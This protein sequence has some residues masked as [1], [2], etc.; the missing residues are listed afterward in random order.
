[1]GGWR[2]KATLGT[3]I[4]YPDFL[5][6][7]IPQ[8]LPW[9]N[10]FLLTA[11][12]KQNKNLKWIFFFKPSWSH[13]SQ[14][15]W[16][17]QQRWVYAEARAQLSS[18]DRSYIILTLPLILSCGWIPCLLTLCFL[19]WLVSWFCLSM[20]SIGSMDS[21]KVNFWDVMYLKTFVFHGRKL[22]DSLTG[23]GLWPGKHLPSNIIFAF[24]SLD[25]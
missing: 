8:T 16:E 19:S 1:M 7:L 13:L 17:L 5:P 9:L 3:C 14:G 24:C 15:L 23:Y 18:E 12:K 4:N 20:F 25:A 21:W 22:I 11:L 6:W 2:Q 10:K